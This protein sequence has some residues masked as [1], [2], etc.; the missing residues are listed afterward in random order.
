MA[1]PP[2]ISDAEWRVMQVLWDADQPLVAADIVTA[3]NDASWSP[4]TIKT[5]LGRLVKKKAVRFTK[6]GKRYLYAAAVSKDQCVRAE[7]RSFLQ[8][9]F[10]GATGPMLARLVEEASLS[11]R[12]IKELTDLLNQKK[13]R[14]R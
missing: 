13:R 6:D 9:V 10:A 3:L 2:T 8:R 1:K 11:D 12:E 7:S 5:M 4:L 14:D